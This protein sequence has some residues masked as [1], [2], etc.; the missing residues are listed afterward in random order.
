MQRLGKYAFRL[1][2]TMALV[3]L[4]SAIGWAADES[5]YTVSLNQPTIRFSDETPIVRVYEEPADRPPEP[6]P[7]WTNH[8]ALLTRWAMAQWNRALEG[9][10]PLRLEPAFNAQDAD[11]LVQFASKFPDDAAHASARQAGGVSHIQTFTHMM[12]ENRIVIVLAQPDGTPFSPLQI[13]TALLHEFGHALGINGHSPY[14][15]DVMS[16]HGNGDSSN[17]GHISPRDV[18]TLKALYAQHA[19]VTN[20][21]GMRVADARAHRALL[22]Q[23]LQAFRAQK[24]DT[25]RAAFLPLTEVYGDD[26][27]LRFLMAMLDYQQA[28][29]HQ[30]LRQFEALCDA[31]TEPAALRDEARLFAAH[32]HLKLGK[33]HAAKDR[34]QQL[35]DHNHLKPQYRQALAEQL[36]WLN[37]PGAFVLTNYSPVY[38][39]TTT[40]NP[41][42]SQPPRTWPHVAVTV[43]GNA[44]N[45]GHWGATEHQPVRIT[46]NPDDGSIELGY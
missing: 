6:L 20:P 17:S 9:Q 14:P 19:Q 29:Y 37:K 22:Q 24:Y 41:V 42:L 12:V 21:T 30:A 32:T 34:L 46:H 5:T 11:I 8:H 45:K 23:G 16:K 33:T 15:D 28:H 18:A 40:L 27:Q 38:Y 39:A 7:E 44:V 26:V 35:A 10:V 36:E 43:D 2:A 13:Q 4:P 3:A 25:A 1:L 31:H